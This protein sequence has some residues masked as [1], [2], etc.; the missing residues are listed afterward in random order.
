MIVVLSLLAVL[1][2]ALSRHMLFEVEAH[3]SDVPLVDDLLRT[4]PLPSLDGRDPSIVCSILV[5][6]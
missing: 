4:W 3:S 1:V 6:G 5:P 2:L